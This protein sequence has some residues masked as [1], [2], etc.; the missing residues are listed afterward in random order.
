[1]F[2]YRL[3]GGERG[4]REELFALGKKRGTNAPEGEF[5]LRFDLWAGPAQDGISA[6]AGF[7]PVLCRFEELIDRAARLSSRALRVCTS[8]CVAC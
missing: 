1:M 3:L 4:V 6:I 2:Y 5:K 7:E 8:A